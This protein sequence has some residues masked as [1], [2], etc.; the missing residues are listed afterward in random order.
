MF[1]SFPPSPLVGL[2]LQSLL[3]PGSRH[4]YGIIT[5]KMAGQGSFWELMSLRIR[6]WDAKYDTDAQAGAIRPAADCAEA[7]VRQLR[8]E[9]E[10]LA[11]VER[12]IGPPPAPSA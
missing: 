2:R 9:H 1:G 8:L 6:L 10:S 11:A 3:G 12:E 4:C 5:L 7:K